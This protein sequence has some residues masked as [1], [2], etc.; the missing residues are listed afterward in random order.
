MSARDFCFSDEK[1]DGASDF[2]LCAIAL[3]LLCMRGVIFVKALVLREYNKF[4]YTDVPMPVCGDGEVLIRV[5]ACAICGSDVHGM[6]GST[7]RRIPPVI[8]G[9]EASGV[10]ER[11]GKSVACF[12]PGDRV[13][14]DSTVYCGICD[15]CKH[16]QINLCDNRM[17]LGVSCG[18][19]RRDGA[20]AEYVSVPERILYA[21]PDGVS[22]EQAAMVEPLSIAFHAVSRAGMGMGQTAVVVGAGMIGLLIIQMLK[23]RGCAHIVAVDISGDKLQKALSLGADIAVNSAKEDAAAK[24]KALGGADTAFEVVGLNDTVNLAIASVKKGG[25]VVLVGNLRPKVDFPLQTVVTGQMNILGTCASSNEYPQCL[26]LIQAGKVDIDAFISA[27]APLSE[28]GDWFKR[29]Y[30]GKEPL[31]KVILR[32]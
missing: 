23:L 3:I 8:M 14:F 16:G 2:E 25:A 1:S 6:D 28:G 21:L 12:K 9:H 4:E 24:I 22:F 32:P 27:V 13:T 5:K 10:I 15:Y 26:Q 29:L 31:M 11:A 20:F 18:D 7:G 17:V 30:E 19:Y